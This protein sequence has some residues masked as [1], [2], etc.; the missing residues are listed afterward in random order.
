L[1][2]PLW[3]E[4]ARTIAIWAA[5]RGTPFD[6]LYL[7]G[8]D[9]TGPTLPGFLKEKL[10]VPKI[11]RCAGA[12]GCDPA[13][14]VASG[15][16]A[17]GTQQQSDMINFAK[18]ESPAASHS[19]AGWRTVAVGLCLILVLASIS[20]GLRYRAQ[21]SRYRQTA[22]TVR[23][24]VQRSFPEALGGA[25]VTAQAKRLVAEAQKR[26]AALGIGVPSSL[27]LL[28]EVTLRI[29]KETQTEIKEVLVDA[30][31]LWIEAE[32]NSFDSVERIKGELG[33]SSLFHSVSVHDARTGV[34][35][36]RVRFRIQMTIGHA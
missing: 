34:G 4:V 10:G 17:L 21:D 8:A 35:G 14:V 33:R 19:Q 9:S 11:E 28:S 18:A 6:K 5:E 36:S 20:L 32:T 13:F 16:A 12:D 30:D 15:L 26:S 27:Q 1:G 24:L 31:R 23:E 22:A 2:E 29:P 3:A 25:D 7:A